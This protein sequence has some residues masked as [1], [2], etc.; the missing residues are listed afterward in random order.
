MS[1]AMTDSR[2]LGLSPVGFNTATTLVVNGQCVY[3]VEEE[4]LIR[5]KRTRNFPAQGIRA[6]LDHAGLAFTDIDTVAVSWNPAINIEVNNAAQSGRAR[7]LGEIFYSVPSNL[8]ALGPKGSDITL[9]QQKISYSDG[10]ELSIAYVN[11]HVAHAA[12][13]FVSPFEEAAV[14][15]VDAFGEKNCVTFSR[16]R[17]NRLE[18]IWTQDFPHTLGSFYSAMTEFCGFA[19]QNDEWKLM[20]AS[21]YGDAD[22]FYAPLMGL[23]DLHE[24]AGFSLD[25]GPFNFHQFHRPG[26]SNAGMETLLGM[27]ANGRDVPLTQDYYDLAASAQRVAEDIYLHLLNQLHRHTGLDSVVIAGGVALNCVANGKVLSQTPFKNIFVPPVPDDSGGSLGAAYYMHCQVNGGQR[28]FVMDA[29]YLGPGFDDAEI[30]A[31]LAKYKLQSERVDNPADCAAGLIA[32]GNIIGWFQGRLEFGDRALGNRSILAD[33][34]D[35]EMKDKVNET[36]K[37][38]EPFRPFAPAIMERFRDDYF[39]GACPTPFMEKAFPIRPE[40]HAEI[41]AVTH[42]DGTG[43]LQTVGEKQNPLFHSLIEAFHKRTGVPVVLNT[44]FNLKG[45]PVVCTPEDAVRTFFSCGLDALVIGN[46]VLRK[47]K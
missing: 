6:A 5:A 47:T 36:I 40:R 8:M 3:A 27:K 7:Y 45:E 29:N 44:S 16:G 37:Y 25:L 4:R 12:C 26:F 41:P 38:R 14:L 22:R 39:E 23:F 20:G 43:R 30:A 15:T 34:R 21:S 18:Q 1:S 9:S 28:D 42:V 13:F 11:H 33:P 10:R 17:G 2:I 35:A 19:P 32:D 31:T 24:E 46:H